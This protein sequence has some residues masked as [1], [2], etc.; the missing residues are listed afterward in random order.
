MHD[1]TGVELAQLVSLGKMLRRESHS[2]MVGLLN[3]T[4]G[5]LSSLGLEMA[6]VMRDPRD[7]LIVV[8]HAGIVQN[9]KPSESCSVDLTS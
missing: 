6:E 1:H 9:L 8:D 3:P 2:F 7:F 5:L 4:T